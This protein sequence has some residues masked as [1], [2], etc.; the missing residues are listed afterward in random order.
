MV[1]LIWHDVPSHFSFF[2]PSGF[3]P[4]PGRSRHSNSEGGY[5][6]ENFVLSATRL[7]EAVKVLTSLLPRFASWIDGSTSM[8]SSDNYRKASLRAT[9]ICQCSDF[10][11]RMR[12]L[13]LHTCGPFRENNRAMTDF[14]KSFRREVIATRK[15]SDSAH[16]GA[17]FQN[18]L[19]HTRNRKLA[20]EMQL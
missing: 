2:S 5:W 13:L 17:V 14:S 3:A 6:L 16:W 20:F 18:S 19:L 10:L 8:R 12:R 9:R 1:G 4:T 11:G 7:V 15:G